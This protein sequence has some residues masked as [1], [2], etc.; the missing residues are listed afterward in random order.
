MISWCYFIYWSNIF[1]DTVYYIIKDDA[2]KFQLAVNTS[3]VG[4]S[5]DIEFS[6]VSTGSYI[7]RRVTKVLDMSGDPPINTGTGEITLA[8][9]GLNTGDSLLYEH[10]G[11]VLR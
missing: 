3:D 10:H 8:N 7:L 4:T 1:S 6:S 9:H 2:D 11:P 5:T